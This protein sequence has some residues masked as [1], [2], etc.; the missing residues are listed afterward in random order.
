VSRPARLHGDRAGALLFE[1][2]EQLVPVQLASDHYLP[3][4]I[5]SMNLED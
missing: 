5:H 1:K 3:F 2:R 4:A